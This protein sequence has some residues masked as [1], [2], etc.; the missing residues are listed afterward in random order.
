MSTKKAKLITERKPMKQK[1]Y[2]VWVEQVNQTCFEV[3]AKDT[4]EA[5]EKGYRKWRKEYGHSRVVSIQEVV[6]K[7]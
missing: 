6:K 7:N 5:E 3:S 4:A 1:K 2:K